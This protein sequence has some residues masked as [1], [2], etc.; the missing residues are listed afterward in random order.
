MKRS[1]HDPRS[2]R[3]FKKANPKE[4]HLPRQDSEAE[5][6]SVPCIL[7][8]PQDIPPP[9]RPPPE[10]PPEQPLL[11]QFHPDVPAAALPVPGAMIKYKINDNN[12]TISMF[13][14]YN[15]S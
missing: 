8:P 14:T 5:F 13:Q 4:F 6:V 9:V 11:E 2:C 3:L 12:A 7:V 15:K 10:P 1:S